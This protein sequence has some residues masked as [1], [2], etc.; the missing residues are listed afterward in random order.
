MLQLVSTAQD[1]Y[2]SEVRP[3]WLRLHLLL[4][5]PIQKLQRVAHNAVALFWCQVVH[6]PNDK[7]GRML[8]T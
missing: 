1:H 2:F 3:I 5:R 8:V 7:F 6:S 4:N